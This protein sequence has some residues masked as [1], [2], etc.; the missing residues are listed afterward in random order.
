MT[1]M[2]NKVGYSH[3]I[4][5]IRDVLESVDVPIL[6]LIPTY[7]EESGISKLIQRTKGVL[8]S[9][10]LL[11][12]ILVVD[13]G[14]SDKTRQIL[15]DLDVDRFYHRKNLGKGDVIK[16]ILGF[17]KDDEI[18]VTMDGDGEH[19]P[20]DLTMLVAPIIRGQADMVIGSRFLSG[21]KDDG[22]S[23]LARKKDKRFFKNVGNWIIRIL[24][25]IFTRV[26]ITDSLSGYRAFKAGQLKSLN[27]N[28]EGFRIE[29]E[30]TMKAIKKGF[31]IVEV[32]IRNG[33][34]RRTSHLHLLTDGVRI[35]LT[36]FR[37][38]LPRFLVPFF[39]WLLPRIPR[40]IGR[41]FN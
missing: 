17:L 8:S 21:Y 1:L 9:F 29:I 12:T 30:A 7:N 32:P 10:S 23:Y 20:G 38:S 36:I 25:L 33:P 18:V 26:V 19:D 22:V 35:V 31:K 3:L 6:V 27:L 2:E 24:L 11:S 40:K 39:D 5:G 16:N 37:E 13:D 34:P 4:D 41:F 28:A 15:D 14:S